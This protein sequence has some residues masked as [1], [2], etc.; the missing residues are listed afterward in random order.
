M[1]KLGKIRRNWRR[2]WFTLTL[3]T[4]KVMY[5]TGQDERTMRGE[6][7]LLDVVGVVLDSEHGQGEVT[8]HVV[9][10]SRTFHLR[11]PS[12]DA[13]RVWYNVLQV[14]TGRTSAAEP[15]PTFQRFLNVI[16]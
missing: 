2:R 10:G 14:I 8:L 7:S 3:Q 5:F 11:P 9:T 12:A 16:L 13:V 1:H 15:V 6:I 4:R